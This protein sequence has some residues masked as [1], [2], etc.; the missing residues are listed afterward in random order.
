MPAH[1]WVELGLVPLMGRAR[2]R[3]MFKVSCGFRRTLSS[4]PDDGWDCVPT[5][6]AVWPEVSQHWSLWA[7][8]C[9]QVFVSK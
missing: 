7:A 4:L 5:L 6:L 9:G 3:V 1:W 8:G 2:P